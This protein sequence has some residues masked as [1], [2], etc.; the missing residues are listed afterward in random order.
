MEFF[1]FK[2][3]TFKKIIF[4]SLCVVLVI[5][6]QVEYTSSCSFTVYFLEILKFCKTCFEFMQ[7]DQADN[8]LV[9]LSG[10]LPVSVLHQMNSVFHPLQFI[11]AS[12][13]YMVK[14]LE[15][16]CVICLVNLS[17]LSSSVIS[18]LSLSADICRVCRS[19]GTPEKPLYHPCVCTGSIKF[20]HQEW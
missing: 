1:Y 3:S 9:A 8:V 2:V 13:C 18:F 5:T 16:N 6:L 15:C 12:F 7:H 17:S 19:E 4:N 14:F 10:D 20:I 11:L